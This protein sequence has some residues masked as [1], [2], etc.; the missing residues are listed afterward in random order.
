MNSKFVHLAIFAAS[1]AA[2][3]LG[4]LAAQAEVAAPPLTY[5]AV[6]D[7]KVYPKPP[8]PKLGPAG[9]IFDD[10]TFH[11]PILRVSDEKTV[12]GRAI[13]T[14]ATAF[15]NPWNANSTLF[16]VL[17]DGSHNIPYH[18][19]PKTMTASRIAGLPIL[20]DIANEIAF[21]RHDANICFGK[22]RVRQGIA[23]FDFAVNKATDFIDV[24]KLT[25]L[26]PGY[27]G[28]LSVSAND[29]LALIFGGGGQDASPYVLLYDLKT[30]KHRLWNTKEGTVDGKPVANAPRF[31]QHSGLIDQSGRYFVTLGPGVRQPI[32]WDTATDEIYP[33]SNQEE[34]HYALG[35]G[36][37]VN[38]SR[39]YALRGLD[40]KAVD[41]AS[42]LTQ[43]PAG[44]PYFAYDSHVSWNNARPGARVPVVLSTYHPFER[45][46][47]KCAWGDEVI[48]LATDGSGKV[49][50]FAQHRSVAHIRIEN[51]P[52]SEQKG[53]NFWD[54]PR[55]NV[56]Q[57]GRFYMFT[58]NWEESVGTDAQGR[59]REDAFIVKL[60]SSQ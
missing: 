33:I 6:S 50:R 47:P 40:S 45:P 5:H 7:T 52:A 26:E 21:S 25:G 18:F 28:T 24:G 59:S 1:F 34:G 39:P 3:L 17:A 2:A 44:A 53:Y 35:Y 60:G 10:P 11:C 13:V 23:Q 43:F 41:K 49:W 51:R 9:F 8:L 20:P 12:E 37:M 31:T 58:S 36:E 48:A 15:S 56:S 4:D 46:D 30:R 54:C 32:V 14:P 55:G 29:V 42:V 16:C 38:C 22:D 27:L 57:D 19:D